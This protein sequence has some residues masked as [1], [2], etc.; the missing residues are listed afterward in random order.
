VALGQGTVDWKEFFATVNK[1]G[2]KNIFIEMDL[3]T[4]KD[5]ATYIHNL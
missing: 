5:S 2:V 4:F 1:G 3:A